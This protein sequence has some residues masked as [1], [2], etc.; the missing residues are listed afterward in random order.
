MRPATH[1]RH[2]GALQIV[3]GALL[4]VGSLQMAWAMPEFSRLTV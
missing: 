3:Q 4:W 2:A 1:R